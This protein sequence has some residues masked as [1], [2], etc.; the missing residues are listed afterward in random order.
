MPKNESRFADLL[1][2]AIN[3]IA[4]IETK[5]KQIVYD[6]LGYL[7]GRQGGSAIQYWVYHKRVPAHLQDI[8]DLARA[9]A[10]RNGWS[11]DAELFA[12]LEAAGYPLPDTLQRQIFPTRFESSQTINNEHTL[13]VN[14]LPSFIVGPP[15]REPRHFYG[16]ERE[17]KRIFNAIGGTVL[18]NV[19][20][21]GTQRS[22][23]TSL[24]H[25]V[26]N[27]TRTSSTL[28]RPGQMHNWLSQPLSYH[29]LFIDFQDPRVCSRAGFFE[30]FLHQLNFPVPVP[31]DLIQFVDTVCRH[32]TNPT[33]VLMDEIQI[34]MSTPE[35]DQTF[36]WGLR[37]L[38][39]NLTEG[40][41]AFIIASQ[42]GPEALQIDQAKPSPFLN[43]F[44][45]LVQ[46]GPFSPEEAHQLITSSPLPF[47]EED[48]RWIIEQSKCWPALIQILCSM[49]LQALNENEP[50]A[51][52]KTE[53]LQA[54]A[55]FLK[56]L[57]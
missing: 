49:R 30:Y 10:R 47:A 25:Y 56:L 27:I 9:I 53:A 45:H 15:I 17:I 35:F 57:T 54:I 20:V 41:L 39:T 36:W 21:I 4:F 14:N 50:G 11:S 44:G 32:L 40:K 8:E 28:L 38:A 24:L 43:I 55:P 37:S 12:F 13:P 52:W 33:V 19:A 1:N 42:R 2:K 31:C 23:K 29:W 51:L 26:K 7:L 3:R 18:Q 16:R 5:T 48:T 22:G 46:L 34:A 6:E